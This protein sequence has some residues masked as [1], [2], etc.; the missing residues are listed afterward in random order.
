MD[1]YEL[2]FLCRPYRFF[3]VA[4][5][6]I[7]RQEQDNLTMEVDLCQKKLERVG[8]CPDHDGWTMMD[9]PCYGP[10]TVSAQFLFGFMHL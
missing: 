7:T 8:Q 6:H 5:G 3:W 2:W 10:T 1:I 9:G 4:P